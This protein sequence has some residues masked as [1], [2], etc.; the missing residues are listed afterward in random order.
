MEYGQYI[1]LC[2]LSKLEAVIRQVIAPYYGYSSQEGQSLLYI[3]TKAIW[4]YRPDNV[5]NALFE[6]NDDFLPQLKSFLRKKVRE[7]R[8]LEHKELELNAFRQCLLVMNDNMQLNISFDWNYE[9]AFW[10]LKS[11]TEELQL[12][13]NRLSLFLDN[14]GAIDRDSKTLLAAKKAGFPQAMELDS[15]K[16]SGVRMA[17][18]LCGFAGRIIRS[19]EDSY[20]YKNDEFM[21][22]KL[23]NDKWF[24]VNEEQFKLYKKIANVFFNINKNYYMS[25]AG[26]YGDDIS[27]FFILFRYFDKFDTFEDYSKTD[28]RTHSEFFNE[29]SCQKLTQDHQRFG[30]PDEPF[31]HKN[32]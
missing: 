16:E 1:Y 29:F 31:I 24:Q 4:L 19:L 26:V 20:R 21:K 30:K 3:I 7:I 13:E 10:G 22:I 11:L 14:E 27:S 2:V 32:I 15:K 23:L 17:D 8:D 6:E 5:V 12:N 28:I 9:A 25:F 18:L